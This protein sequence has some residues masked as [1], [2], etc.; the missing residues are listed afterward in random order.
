MNDLWFT[1]HFEQATSG[2]ESSRSNLLNDHRLE[3]GR[4]L[5]VGRC[6]AVFVIVGATAVAHAF[7]FLLHD[8]EL[9]TVWLDF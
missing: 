5:I 2:L 9:W 6:Y 3:R 1:F 4:V 8:V 7:R